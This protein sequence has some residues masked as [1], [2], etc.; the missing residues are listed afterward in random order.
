ME[1]VMLNGF[2][3]LVKF[4]TEREAVGFYTLALV[5]VVVIVLIII[6]LWPQPKQRVIPQP[7]P[8]KD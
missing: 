3:G 6:E 2:F 5:G 8:E 7:A 4:A 1:D